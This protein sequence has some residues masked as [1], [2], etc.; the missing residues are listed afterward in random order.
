L[1]AVAVRLS[2]CAVADALRIGPSGPHDPDPYEAALQAGSA[3]LLELELIKGTTRGDLV[4]QQHLKQATA[5]LRFA[6][7]QMRLAREDDRRGLGYG[8]VMGDKPEPK[9]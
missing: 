4:L 6:L 9:R 7:V 1:L 2:I 3:C 8:F 5:S